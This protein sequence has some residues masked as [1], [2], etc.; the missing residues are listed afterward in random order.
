MKKG[1][2]FFIVLPLFLICAF[3]VTAV[4]MDKREWQD[5]TIYSIMIDRFNNGDNTNDFEVNTK[6]PS[7]YHGGDFEGIIKQLDNLKDMGFTAINLSPIFD[8]ESAGYHGYWVNDFYET[9]EHFGSI[10]T[11][12]ELVKEAH[13]REMKVILDMEI[14]YVGA[15]HSWLTD[16]EKAN[17]FHQVEEPSKESWLGNRPMLN[18]DNAEVREYFLDVATY[19]IEETKIDGY[20]FYDVQQ[21]PADFWSQ[22]TATIKEGNE[23]IYL[24]GEVS[25]GDIKSIAKYKQAGID[26]FT[27]YFSN[28]DLR[29]AYAQ[30]DQSMES[31]LTKLEQRE[32]IYANPN[33]V[34]TFFDNHKTVRFTTDAAKLN[35]HPGPRWKLGLTYLYTTPGIPMVYYGSEIALYGEAAPENYQ[36]MNFMTDKELIEYITQLGEIRGKTPSLTRGSMEVLFEE[37]GMLIYKREYEGETSV[38]AINNTSGTRSVEISAADLQDERELRGMLAGDLIRS[39][40]GNYKIV[41]DREEAEIY[42]LAEKTGINIAYLIA[43]SAVILL[44]ILFIVLLKRRSKENPV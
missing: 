32:N 10:E 9:E 1:I 15:N 19:W 24:L 5:E 21:I 4:E 7:A 26:G 33:L 35:E 37:N 30:P 25:S 27:D 17:W 18:F 38:I 43:I 40:D 3:P 44:F 16:P 14:Y 34:G 42:I 41:L 2:L 28:E 29:A 39:V 13:E 36:Q 20:R 12:K 22:L 8:N 23:D 31:V 11:F 6:D